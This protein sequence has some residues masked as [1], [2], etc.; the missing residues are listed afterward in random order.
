MRKNQTTV[1]FFYSFIWKDLKKFRKFLEKFCL[2]TYLEKL[3]CNN[4][5][6]VFFI[7]QIIRNAIT[8]HQD[9]YRYALVL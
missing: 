5:I 6:T 7:W 8:K 3:Y 2:K 9:P 4:S 1:N